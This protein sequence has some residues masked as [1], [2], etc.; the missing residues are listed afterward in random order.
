M[1][2][3]KIEQLLNIADKA[4]QWPNLKRI[5]DEALETL[6]K[7]AAPNATRDSV[8]GVE[9]PGTPPM[10]S[11]TRVSGEGQTADEVTNDD[12]PILRRV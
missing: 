8:S 7:F 2:W 3:D 6:A 4:R 11:D 10:V 12:A 5:H 9:R 1:N